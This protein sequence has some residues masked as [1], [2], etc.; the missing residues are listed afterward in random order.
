M[1]AATQMLW[2]RVGKNSYNVLLSRAEL[3]SLT[4]DTKGHNSPPDL[5]PLI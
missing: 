5:S 4:I 1:D 3:L 2:F